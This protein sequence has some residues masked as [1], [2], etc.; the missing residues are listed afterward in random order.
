M[1]VRFINGVTMIAPMMPVRMTATA[2]SEG[3]ACRDSAMPMATPAVTKDGVTV[4]EEIELTDPYENMGAQLVK[5]AASKTTDTTA[6][7][8]PATSATS[9]GTIEARTSLRFS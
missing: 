6:V 7:T 1:P 5:E 3:S 4:A 2:A 9:I 8:D